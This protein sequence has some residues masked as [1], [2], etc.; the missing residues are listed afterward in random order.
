MNKKY[1]DK[2]IEQSVLNSIIFEPTLIEICQDIGLESKH[3]FIPFF[4]KLYETLLKLYESSVVDEYFIKESMGNLYQEDMMI[5][6]LAITPISNI[7]TYG[8]K[9]KDLYR[10]REVKSLAS[11]I[12]KTIEEQGD[13]SETLKTIHEGLDSLDEDKTS[14]INIQSFDNIESRESEFVCK[15]WL[16]FPKRAVSMV[17]AG[18]GVGKSFIML[19]AAMRMVESER[20]KVFLWLSEDPVELSKYRFNLI[21]NNLFSMSDDLIRNNLHIAGSDSETI[22]F[23]EEDRNS[24]KVNGKF[25]QFKKMLSDYDVIIL[26]PL[27]AMF[28]GDENNNAHARKFINLFSRWA[29]KE[30][31]CVIFIHHSSKNSSQSRGASAFV[32][33]VR[34]VYQV[35]LVKNNDGEQ[36]EN[37]M[38]MIT[39]SKDNNGAKRYFGASRAKR[40]IFVETK[41]KP[42]EI[43]FE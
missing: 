9:I 25:Y 26:D 5:E 10:L 32:D 42:L 30:Q 22:H 2:N 18:G 17:T 31:K 41:K 34:L 43:V 38:R 8:L 28:G 36:I 7:S 33:A 35:D 3:F 23:L 29:T 6:T 13:Y 1:F 27:I 37:H 14:L 24:V 20:L 11:N 40:E 16:P 19:Q 15:G 21:K 12:L 4:Q 39:I